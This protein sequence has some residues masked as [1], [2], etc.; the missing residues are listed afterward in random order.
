M[1]YPVHERFTTFQGEGTHMG[2]PAFFIR[3]F[4]CPVHCPW[5]DSAGTWHK[6]WVPTHI[7]RMTEEQL[8]AEFKA[9][10]VPVAVITGGEPAVHDLLPLT[11]ALKKADADVHLE[12]SGAFAF[13]GPVDWMVL[14]PKK[15]KLP[16]PSMVQL[17]DEFKVIVEEVGDIEFYEE[18]LLDLGA[19]PDMQVW[20]HPEWSKRQDKAILK[21]ICNVVVAGNGRYRA[22]W[23]LHKLYQVDAFDARTRPLVPLGGNPE[24]G[25]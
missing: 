11:E 4:G 19:G 15:W 10:G 16:V 22:G 18:V 20:L 12:T 23:Q 25:I 13:R 7:D 8:A 9:S 6:D 17:A 3:L 1:N 2:R 14:S 24:K 21:E 5:C